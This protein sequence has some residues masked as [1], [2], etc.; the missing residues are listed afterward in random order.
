MKINYYGSFLKYIHIWKNLNGIIIRKTI[1]LLD[2]IG[3][4]VKSPVTGMS[5][6]LLIPWLKGSRKSP[7]NIRL[8]PRLLLASPTTYGNTLLLKT[9]VCHEEIK[10]VPTRSFTSTGWQSWRWEVLGLLLEEK[11]NHQYH[12]AINPATYNS[13]LPTRHTDATVEQMLP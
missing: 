7:S 8:L 6:I 4:Q 9:P 3:H 11:S 1:P 5:C 10:L 12:P 2:I 13:A